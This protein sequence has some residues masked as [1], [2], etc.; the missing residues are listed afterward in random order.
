VPR[1]K[2][3][4]ELGLPFVDTRAWSMSRI[5]MR[6]GASDREGIGAKG[7]PLNYLM[8][9]YQID[10]PPWRTSN[11]SEGYEVWSRC[12]GVTASA[13]HFARS[14]LRMRLGETPGMLAVMNQYS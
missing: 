10:A 14:L 4:Q 3:L 5:P 9:R 13:W 11:R 2:S 7:R 1:A 8:H 12:S 6:P